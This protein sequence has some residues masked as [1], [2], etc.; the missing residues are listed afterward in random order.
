MSLKRLWSSLGANATTQAL[1]VGIQLISIPLFLSVWNTETYGIW[2]LLSTIPTYIA[3]SDFGVLTVA[4]NKMT[5]ARG[6]GDNT[7]QIK[8]FQSAILLLITSITICQTSILIVTL[9]FYQTGKATATTAIAVNLLTICALI[10]LSNNLVDAA[11]RSNDNYPRGIY[12]INAARLLEWSGLCIGLFIGETIIWTAIGQFIGRTVGST[13]AILWT[14]HRIPNLLWRTTYASKTE[15]KIMIKPGIAFLAFP[16][17]NAISIQGMT[18]VVGATLGVTAAATF[19]IYRT[20][21]RTGLQAI[22]I[23]G[24]SLWPEISRAYG[25]GHH[26][27]I[28]SIRKYGTFTSVV[29]AIALSTIIIIFGAQIISNWTHSQVTFDKILLTLLLISA[30]LTAVWQMG[31]V[32][33]AATNQHTRLS[34]LTLLGSIASVALTLLIAPTSE[35]LAAPIALIILELYIILSTIIC[36]KHFR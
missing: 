29:L 21:S 23:I 13:I 18:L 15:I 31:M 32:Q 30:T 25:A 6:K 20:L 19:N 26:K 12:L 14:I 27:K 10:S 3:L 4:T 2:V 7:Q 35:E 9:I 28:Q 8:T 24:R 11:N 5:I 22:T 16:L 36:L 33:L 1:T 34:S 17:S